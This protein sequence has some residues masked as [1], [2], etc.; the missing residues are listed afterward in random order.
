M[1]VPSMWN[2]D[3]IRIRLNLCRQGFGF[4]DPRGV[5]TKSPLRAEGGRRQ[6]R[7][8]FMLDSLLELEQ[9]GSEVLAD[10]SAWGDFRGG[11]I[12]ATGGRCG[13]LNW[14]GHKPDDRGHGPCGGPPWS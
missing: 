13:T 10:I 1:P 3:S 9:R 4:S 6:R 2:S 14:H 11:S 8:V 12:S 7:H 5:Y